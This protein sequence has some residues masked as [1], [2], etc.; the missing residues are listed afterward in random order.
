MV[1]DIFK[2]QFNE[3]I[4]VAIS[5]ILE[6]THRTVFVLNKNKLVGVVSEGDILRSLIYK[7]KINTSVYTIMNKSFIFLDKKDTNKAKEL[8]IKNLVPII[9]I[10]N[11]KME[12]IDLLT[13]E[14]Y[15]LKK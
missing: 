12:L 10:V 13:L 4:E 3:K 9:P 11:K 15:L 8:F 6:N 5:K 7:K 14:D 1:S 2:I